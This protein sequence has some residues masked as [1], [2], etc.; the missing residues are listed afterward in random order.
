MS[1]T[2]DLQDK[3]AVIT[4]AGRGIGKAAALAL[5]EAG[6]KVVLA[7]RTVSQLEEAAADILSRT[8]RPAL[9]V[10][11]D[12]SRAEAV[13]QLMAK[14]VEAFGTVHILVN[15]AGVMSPGPLME[16]TE[17]DWDRV[18]DTNL[19]SVF[20]CTQAAGRHMIQQRWGR[21]INIASTGGVIAGPQNAAYHSSKAAVI[22]FTKAVAIEWIR[23]NINVNAIGPG[24]VDTELVDRFIQKRSR[25]EMSKH[26]PIR[27]FADSRELADVVVFLASDLD[28]YVVG[29]HIIVDGGLTNP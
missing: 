16:Q 2:L 13:Q 21:I 27:R 6:A 26:I 29:E 28:S 14:T 9:A 23:Y 18:L 17:A 24:T 22:H 5:A 4:G 20:L 3:V 1:L 12:I 15:N 25:E 8:G 11:T 10:P 7:A 19:K